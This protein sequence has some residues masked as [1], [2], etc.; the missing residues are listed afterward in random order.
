MRKDPVLNPSANRIAGR[1]IDWNSIDPRRGELYPLLDIA[2]IL[3]LMIRSPQSNRVI[4]LMEHDQPFNILTR[5]HRPVKVRR[6]LIRFTSKGKPVEQDV[7]YRGRGGLFLIEHRQVSS[8]CPR[9]TMR[10]DLFRGP[11]AIR[12]TEDIQRC[13]EITGSTLTLHG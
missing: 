2:L 9:P 12:S 10:Q 5:V 3:G 1:K 11:I 7:V 4:K 8:P 6:Q 13:L